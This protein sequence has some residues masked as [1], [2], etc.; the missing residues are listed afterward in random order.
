M[1]KLLIRLRKVFVE[2]SWIKVLTE[3][4]IITSA[5]GRLIEGAIFTV[6]AWL[7]TFMLSWLN[8]GIR[9]ERKATLFVLG[10]WFAKTILEAILKSIRN[11][12]K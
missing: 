4:K 3:N 8:S 7:L 5:V 1:I 9:T 10:T 6:Y 12:K 2:L 11:R